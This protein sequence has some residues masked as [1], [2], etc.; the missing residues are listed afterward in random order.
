M[1][2]EYGK[3]TPISGPIS[4]T[5]NERFLDVNNIIMHNQRHDLS[6]TIGSI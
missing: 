3:L 2:K 4:L 6:N 5:K 1:Q